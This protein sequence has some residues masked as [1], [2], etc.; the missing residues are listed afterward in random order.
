MKSTIEWIEI[1]K[2]LP[3]EK[4]NILITNG[5]EILSGVYT[6]KEFYEFFYM[7]TA[8][9]DTWSLEA[10]DSSWVTHWASMPYIFEP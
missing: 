1:D 7:S 6:Q 9:A 5:K 3:E 8:F 2:K 10:L 4:E